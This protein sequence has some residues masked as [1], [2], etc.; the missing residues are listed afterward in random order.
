MK[1]DPTKPG[2]LFWPPLEPEEE[3][4]FRRGFIV[5][6]LAWVALAVAVFLTV[7]CQSTPLAY[8]DDSGFLPA[9]AGGDPEYLAKVNGAPC[10]D[11]RGQVGMCA[12]KVKALE[13][14]Q[15]TLD[16]EPY[17]YRLT[18]TCPDAVFG[19]Q[20]FDVLANT[21]WAQVIPHEKMATLPA[22]LCIGEVYPADRPGQVSAR[23]EV[24][25]RVLATKLV[26]RERIQIEQGEKA[27]T[28]NLGAY[29]L[30]GRVCVAGQC[31][32]VKR[33]PLVTWTPPVAPSAVTAYSESYSMRFNY[34][35]GGP[36]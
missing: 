12:L 8:Q 2:I 36:P 31:K 24:R 22:F 6:A 14:L 20:S 5:L 27:T 7:G 34:W 33:Q 30:Y 18:L 19:S 23:F 11:M 25:V 16:P 13:D 35:L 15:L 3:R 4:R 9:V 10:V 32:A 29:A 21:G 28:I 1:T 26:D 17:A